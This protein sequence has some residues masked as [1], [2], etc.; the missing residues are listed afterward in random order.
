VALAQALG[1]TQANGLCIAVSGSNDNYG[2]CQVWVSTDGGSSYPTMLGTIIG[3]P[4]MGVVTA[5]YPLHANPD[6][7]NSLDVDLTESEGELSSFTSAQQAQL[8]SIALIDGGG[9]SSAGGYTTTIPYEIVAYKTVALTSAYKYTCSPSILR[10]QLGTVPADHPASPASVFV[11][12]S[13]LTSIFKT[14]VPSGSILGNTL[15][16]K[17]ATFN[18]F[19][20]GIQDLSDCTPYTYQVTGSTNPTGS[21]GGGS[22]TITPNP[23]L[24]QGQIGGWP[25]IDG[26]S[27]TWSNP[28]DIYFPSITVN[29][30]TGPV[31]YSANDSGTSAFT[32]PGQTVFVCIYDPGHAGGT[33]TVDIQSTNEH[34]TTAG[35]VFLGQITSSTGSSG[36]SGHSGGSSAPGGPQDSGTQTYAISV[37]GTVVT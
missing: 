18:Q 2:G 21:T 35:Y 6:G 27:A 11:D 36:S 25:G 23:C 14:Q 13:V 22:Y 1:M 10:G 12:L 9:S 31:T 15:Y 37:N 29:Y 7:S 28:D 26:S 16:F 34:A 17:F 4:N 33:P 24:Y 20:S 8:N 5:D 19:N 30:A 32:G 3:N